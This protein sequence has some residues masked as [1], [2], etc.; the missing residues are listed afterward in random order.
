MRSGAA[1][2]A[3][4]R[5][6]YAAVLVA[7]SLTVKHRRPPVDRPS[8]PPGERGNVADVGLMVADGFTAARGIGRALMESR[9]GLGAATVGVRKIELHVASPQRGRARPVR[10]TIGYRRGRS[11]P[12]GPLPACGRLSWTRSSWRS[13]V[14]SGYGLERSTVLEEDVGLE[15][16]EE[17]WTDDNGRPNFTRA[18]SASPPTRSR[19]PAAGLRVRRASS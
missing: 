8:T 10:A 16:E 11:P 5:R 17:L 1:L 6:S 3:I 13:R 12:P 18:G 19:A 9:R 14:V 4:R 15:A 7:E 2:K